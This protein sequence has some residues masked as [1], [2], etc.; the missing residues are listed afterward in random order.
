MK[1]IVFAGP[2][3]HGV[4]RSQFHNVDFRPPAATGDLLR[5]S[6]EGPRCIGLIDGLYGTTTAVWHKEILSSLERGICVLGAASMGALRAA[7]C[8]AFGMR[9]V[10]KI[11]LDFAEGRRTAD[12]DVAVIHAPEEFDFAPLSVAL[13]EVEE[14]INDL[15]NT[16][17][18]TEVG[19][20]L[21][22]A[23]K[24]H[25]TIRT[26]QSVCRHAG[27]DLD[28]PEMAAFLS[29]R[30]VRSKRA[31]AMLLIDEVAKFTEDQSGFPERKWQLERTA[32][33]ENLEAQILGR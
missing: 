28:K 3:I 29:E 7:E 13:I 15:S 5:A 25:F 26:W 14:T 30:H 17:D 6:F 8:S 19:R 31:D 20:L 10:G 22:S 27:I 18:A 9:G 11:Y 33:Y 1:A 32:F 23:R 2:S 21:D 24:L 16:L 12:A 4:D